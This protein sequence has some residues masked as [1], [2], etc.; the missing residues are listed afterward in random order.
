V[1]DQHN[2]AGVNNHHSSASLFMESPAIER[3][4]SIRS[5]VSGQPPRCRPGVA[6]SMQP[7]VLAG[8]VI[9]AT[10]ENTPKDV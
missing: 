9:S 10:P 8:S 4:L 1:L 6:P 3:Y 5:A 2:P 7:G